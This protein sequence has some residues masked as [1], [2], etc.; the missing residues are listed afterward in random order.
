MNLNEIAEV[1]ENPILFQL[2]KDNYQ[3]FYFGEL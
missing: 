3:S 1:T 2:Q